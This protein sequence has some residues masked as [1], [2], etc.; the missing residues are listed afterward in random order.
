[1]LPYEFYYRVVL[2]GLAWDAFINT[3]QFGPIH[4]YLLEHQKLALNQ[5]CEHAQYNSEQ[6]V[7]TATQVCA[8]LPEGNGYFQ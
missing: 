3:L 2:P 1:M 6:Y 8:A 7:W 5:A 4:Q